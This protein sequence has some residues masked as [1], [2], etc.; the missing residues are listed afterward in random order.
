MCPRDCWQEEIQAQMSFTELTT[1]NFENA[2]T[3]WK[4]F[5][6]FLTIEDVVSMELFFESLTAQVYKIGHKC[7]N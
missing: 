1:Q 3:V 5:P 4:D 6:S 2:L 7:K